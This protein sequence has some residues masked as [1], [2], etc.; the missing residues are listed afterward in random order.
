MVLSEWP[1]IRGGNRFTSVGSWRG[2][3]APIEYGGVTFGLR[4]H[5]FRKVVALPRR[6]QGSFEVALD[7]DSVE[8]RD[9]EALRK[10]GWLLADP[11]EIARDPDIYRRYI[12]SSKAEFMAT[13]ALAGSR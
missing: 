4:A 13:K 1:T 8:H 7:I 2:P 10:N 12:Q 9:L 5:E 3:Y 11:R 6:A